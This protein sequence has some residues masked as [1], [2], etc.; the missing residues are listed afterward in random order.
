[1]ATRTTNTATLIGNH[2]IAAG[3][4]ILYS[5]YLL[6]HRPD[7][8]PHPERFDPYRW[9]AQAN[10]PPRHAF[11]PFGDGA[12]KCIGDIYALTLTTLTLASIAARWTLSPAIQGPVRPA[13]RAVLSPQRLHL[14]IHQRALIHKR[15]NSDAASS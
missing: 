6:H 1:M 10:T 8:Y 9:D 12:R 4:T 13:P 14:R 7:L 3:T 11:V 2:T 15:P 5:P